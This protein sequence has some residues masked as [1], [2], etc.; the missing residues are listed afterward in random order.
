MENTKKKNNG[1]QQGRKQVTNWL[2]AQYTLFSDLNQIWRLL[3]MFIKF[4]LERSVNKFE[5]LESK[6]L[7]THKGLSIIQQLVAIAQSI[8]KSK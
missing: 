4:V 2:F 8:K 7:F 5:L 1:S 6:S 3:E